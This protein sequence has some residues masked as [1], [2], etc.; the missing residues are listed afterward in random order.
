[1]AV[2]DLN[3]ARRLKAERAARAQAV[4]ADRLGKKAQNKLLRSFQRMDLSLLILVLIL[5]VFGLIMLFSSSLS[6]AYANW[7]DPLYYVKRQLL[8]T[9][10][11][12]AVALFLARCVAIDFFR[13]PIFLYGAYGVMVLLL[14][15]TMVAGRE[16]DFGGTRWLGVGSFSFQPSELAKVAI[17]YC[18]AAYFSQTRRE[19]SEG[20]HRARK[21]ANQ[22][23]L[24]AF[25][26]FGLPVC[27]AA[28][29]CL[30]ILI[31]PHFSGAIIFAAV[32]AALF[33]VARLPGR[34]WKRGILM[35]LP[36][37]LAAV[38]LAVLFLPLFT[39]QDVFSFID[40]RFAH[41][42]QRMTIYTNPDEVSDDAIH[43]VRQSRYALGSGGLLGKGLGMGQQ[44][45]GFLP[46]VYNDY[47]LPSIGEELGF[48][49][50]AAVTLLFS[51]FCLFGMRI[52]LSA[53]DSFSAMIAYG[54]T[55]LIAIEAFLNIA[56]AAEVIPSTGISLPFFSYGG[57]SHMIFLLAVGLLLCVSRSGRRTDPQLLALLQ[58]EEPAGNTVPR[59]G[60]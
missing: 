21:A 2:S 60:N 5:L 56:V 32:S 16:G 40:Q 29:P 8:F 26:L 52:A 34:V 31:Q 27:A 58:D 15:L 4:A 45:S 37:L 36:I 42:R 24:E 38:L 30:L 59:S 28:L 14:L 18:L 17:I 44:K 35:L 49:G 19:L 41:V 3:R 22:G 54:V 13:R 50:T 53:K 7:N 12:L 48:V 57:S 39:G 20:R 33:F 10:L 6:T 11:G 1:M 46:M 55:F 51:L 9:L 43:Q 47:I 23:W 25:W